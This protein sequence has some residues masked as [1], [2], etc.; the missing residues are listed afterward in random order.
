MFKIIYS[1]IVSFGRDFHS[2]PLDTQPNVMI[3]KSTNNVLCNQY[4]N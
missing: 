1:S 2:I 4:G 3:N